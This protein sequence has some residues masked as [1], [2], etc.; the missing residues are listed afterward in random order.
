MLNHARSPEALKV[1]RRLPLSRFA[2]QKTQQ[3]ATK[4]V[5]VK[6]AVSLKTIDRLFDQMGPVTAPRDRTDVTTPK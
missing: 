2:A 3:N 1:A 4:N 6:I 5:P